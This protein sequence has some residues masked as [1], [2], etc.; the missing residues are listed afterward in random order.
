MY[1]NDTT[2]FRGGK[3]AAY[4]SPE[5]HKCRVTANAGR[6]AIEFRFN[7]ASKGG[8]TTV[9]LLRIGRGGWAGIFRILLKL[10]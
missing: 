5:T 10:I 7:V 9:V 1:L 6:Q 8:G 3:T 2:V 4:L